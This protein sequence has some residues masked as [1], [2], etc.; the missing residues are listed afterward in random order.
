MLWLL[1]LLRTS[2]LSWWGIKTTA[3]NIVSVEFLQREG[4]P[5]LTF[6]GNDKLEVNNLILGFFWL[7]LESSGA[8]ASSY[9]WDFMLILMRDQNNGARHCWCWICCVKLHCVQKGSAQN[10][11]PHA[12]NVI[13]GLEL[14]RGSTGWKNHLALYC[15]IP[16]KK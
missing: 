15:S 3:R 4:F 6:R 1:L 2:C 13:A 11:A 16:D 9:Y 10:L 7:I 8:L 14:P 12:D 5:D